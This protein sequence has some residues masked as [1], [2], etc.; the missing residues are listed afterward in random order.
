MKAA[1]T[2]NQRPVDPLLCPL[3]VPRAAQLTAAVAGLAP[4]QLAWV[5][6]YLAGL[7]GVAAPAR[8]A[9]RTGRP[10]RRGR[11]RGCGRRS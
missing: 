9:P 6:G 8:T 4:L 3:D 5:S 1:N 2:L 7:A 11:A 10:A